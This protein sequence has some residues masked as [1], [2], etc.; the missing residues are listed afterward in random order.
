MRDTYTMK[1]RMI[2]MIL[3]FAM[4]A[5]YLP[6]MIYRANA[7]SGNKTVDPA[8]IHGWK[9]Y[10]GSDVMSTEYTGGVWTDK[11][12]FAS[13]ADYMSAEGVENFVG[14]NGT[15]VP[16]EVMQMLATDPE[17][18]LIALSAITA[19]KSIQ[20][21][22]S[23]PMDTVFVMD[24]SGSMQGSNAVAMVQ[25]T[26]EAIHTLLKQNSNNRVAVILYSGNHDYGNSATTTASMLLPLASYTTTDTMTVGDKTIPAYLTI[27][28]SGSNQTIYVAASVDNGS[29]EDS[30]SVQGGTYIQNGL[31]QAWNAF[32]AV[33]DTKVAEGQLQAGVQRTPV[34]VLMGDG[35]PTAATTSYNNVGTSNLGDGSGTSDRMAFLT[36]LTA[37]WVRSKIAAHYNTQ[38]L[39][40]TLG[41]GVNNNSQ[42]VSVLNPANSSNN[43]SNYWSKYLAGTNGQ[44]VS[45]VSG[46]SSWSVYKDALVTEK[47]YVD[48]CWMTS[49]AAGIVG[50]FEEI[51]NTIVLQAEQHSTLVEVEQGPNMSGYITFEDELGELIEVKA[52][53][54]LSIGNIIFTGAEMAKGF[55]VEKMGTAE[56]PTAYGDE[57]IRT[58]KERLG[59]DT[60]TAHNLVQ[61]AYVAGQLNYTSATEYSNYIGWYADADGNYL[62]FWQESYGME[63]APDGAVYI[64]KSYGYMGTQTDEATASDMMHVVVMVHTRI[65]DGH[66]TIVYKIPA[67]LIPSVTYHIEVNGN[68]P[69][70]IKSITR[71]GA[72]P[73]RLLAEVGL[74]EEINA[75]N[76]KEKIAQHIAKGGHVHENADGSYT[77]YTNLWGYGD[78]GE[79]NYDEPL[80]HQV[81]ES[82]FH[83]AL[84]NERY[85]HVKDAVVYSNASGTVYTGTAAPTGEGYYY[86]RNYYEVVNGKAVYTTK[87]APLAAETLE[88]AAR[89]AEGWY[90]PAGTPQQLARFATAKTQNET[91]TLAYAWNPVTIYDESGY[92]SYAFLG[93][94]GSF[95]IA[96]AQGIAIHKTVTQ[97][98]EGAPT[99]FTFRVTLNRT[100]QNPIITDADGNPL[101]GA[102]T[103]D[104]NVIS[105]KIKADETVV[106]TGIP[107]GTAYTV[108]EVLTGHYTATILAV[109][110]LCR[111]TPLPILRL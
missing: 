33:S 13:F 98:V 82:H 95:T 92:D 85:Y 16:R 17:N 94:N 48:K 31:Y 71:E 28:G 46:Y 80:T 15:A 41:F 79:V 78:G 69:T 59:I 93:N 73:M 12:V 91:G 51:V 6:G 60:A 11:S 8:T 37:A 83:P 30:K 97:A 45:I 99:E 40:Y 63:N 14:P 57:F 108:E 70:Q 58:V 54:G 62:G 72:D 76:L 87:Y 68:D 65:S 107:T 81:T 90:I 100:V 10:F 50:A 96:P 1:K 77:F 74:R 43:L 61:N 109:P 26:N 36:Q 35:A 75:V 32:S 106:I 89:G 39:F 103:V 19:N 111:P 7:A 3:C 104:G 105:V 29:A 21:S 56:E 22:A 88:K 20:G 34:L 27:S 47:N 84:E 18:F 44:N 53:K 25:A 55:T 86:A 2:A 101:P 24:I 38:P 5:T 42:A 66:Q 110:A 49:D 52:I 67:S 9:Q 102:A 23:T 4:I 64:N